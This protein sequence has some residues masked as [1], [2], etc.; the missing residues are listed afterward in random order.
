MRIRSWVAVM[1]AM[2][3]AW[4]ARAPETHAAPA[5]T[6]DA[7]V[8]P[9]STTS[10]PS[11]SSPARP[12]PPDS[13]TIARLSLAIAGASAVRVEIGSR[14]YVLLAPRVEPGGIA[15]DG[16]EHFP[17]PRPAV[18]VYTE[19]DTIPPPPRPIPWEAV[20]GLERRVETRKPAVIF[21]AAVG[22]LLVGGFA[23]GFSRYGGE[24]QA[25]AW[26]HAVAGGAIG[27]GVGAL[28]GLPFRTPSWVR[29]YPAPPRREDRRR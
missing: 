16:L 15:Y 24:D 1:A 8:A 14:A 11:A 10:A 3:A 20:N 18:I 5:D 7:A 27:A 2:M 25:E 6:S 28:L 13:A 4:S 22:A 29:E 17:P 19:W 9:D 23:Y 26:T 21:G 12:A